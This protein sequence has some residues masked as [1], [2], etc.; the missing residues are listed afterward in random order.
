M[1][2]KPFVFDTT[3]SIPTWMIIMSAIVFFPL[4]IFLIFLRLKANTKNNILAGKLLF[5]AGI[6]WSFA[7]IVIT[8]QWLCGSLKTSTGAAYPLGSFLLIAAVLLVLAKLYLSCGYQLLQHKNLQRSSIVPEHAMPS[9]N[10]PS[11]FDTQP[12]ICPGCGASNPI[13]ASF[14]TECEYCGTPLNT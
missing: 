7:A 2:F 6:F 11:A 1:R 12:L 4:A 8:V 9:K 3:N 14:N 13:N 10:N 5:G